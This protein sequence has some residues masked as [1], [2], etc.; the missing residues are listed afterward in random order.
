MFRALLVT[1]VLAAPL[2]GC[3]ESGPPARGAEQVA[4][5]YV[6]S[7]DPAKCDDAALPFLERQTR[8]RGEAARAACRRAAARLR[9]PRR[10]RVT[11]MVR[12][13]DRARVR[14]EADGQ[15]VAIELERRDG[16]WLVT[17]FGD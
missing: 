5:E 2:A 3:G 15:R 10:V 7:R 14:L 11:G 12:E 6:A 16:R 8:E 1:L 17:G 9:P 13:G 4:R